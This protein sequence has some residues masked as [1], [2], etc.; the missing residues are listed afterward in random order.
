EISS[1]LDG[2]EQVHAKSSLPLA[3]FSAFKT[4]SQHELDGGTRYQASLDGRL[5][6]NARAVKKRYGPAAA[7]DFRSHVYSSTQRF[8]PGLG[9]QP[10]TLAG[11]W[12]R[13]G[14]RFRH[15]DYW[16]LEAGLLEDF[17]NTELERQ[18]CF[19]IRCDFGDFDF[20]GRI[21]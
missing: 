1:V 13:G 9:W 15:I 14:S 11:G 6:S 2:Y 18:V 17:A 19:D 7:H 5:Y 3:S 21:H 12:N 8:G 16:I 4:G 20:F 10:P